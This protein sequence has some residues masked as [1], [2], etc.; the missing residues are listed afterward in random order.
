MF[1][2]VLKTD[3]HVRPFRSSHWGCSFEKSVLKDLIK[4]TGKHPCQS[5][6]FNTVAGLRPATLFQKRLWHRCFPVNF[7]TFLKTRILKNICEQF[8]LTF[9]FIALAPRVELLPETYLRPCQKY[10]VELFSETS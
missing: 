1:D 9:I 7:Q 4:F 6:F 8:L 2:W 5:L 10:L 3:H